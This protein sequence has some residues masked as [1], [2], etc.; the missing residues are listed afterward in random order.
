M[1]NNIIYVVGGTDGKGN[2]LNT[3]QAYHV[4]TNTWTEEAPLLVGKSEPSVGLAGTKRIGFTIFAADG[5]ESS[6]PSGDTEGY[7][8]STNVWSSLASGPTA[9]NEACTGAIGSNLY[10]A[11]GAN[12]AGAALAVTESFSVSRDKWKKL[13]S[14]ADSLAR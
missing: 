3:V 8:T 14:I 5:T 7:D 1:E 13:A 4:A 12:S 9:R 10:P 11:G 2:C 6:G